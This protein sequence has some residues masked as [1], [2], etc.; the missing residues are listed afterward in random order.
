MNISNVTRL[1]HAYKV[2][3]WRVQRQWVGAALLVVVA[4]TMIATLYLDV[5]SQA[6]IAGREI[7]DLHIA[8]TL[9]QQASADLQTEY[10]ALTA[11]SVM[12][13]RARELGFRPMEYSE[14]EY[15]AVPGYFVFEP[16]VLSS[17]SLPQFSS[18]TIL[19]EYTI[20]LLDWLDEALLTSSRGWQ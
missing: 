18:L 6:A 11:S 2:A 8:I 9:S 12:K 5:T 19:P 17:A 4:V 15:L 7:Q 14:A 1:A 13:Q 16:A 20:S 3:P 10:A